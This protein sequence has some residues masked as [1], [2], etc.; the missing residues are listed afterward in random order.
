MGKLHSIKKQLLANW[1][2]KRGCNR[3]IENKKAN[4]FVT[5]LLKAT[6]I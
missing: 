6:N 5:K 4:P 2:E 3:V 1:K